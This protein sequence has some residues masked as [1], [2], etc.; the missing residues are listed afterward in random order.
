MH[1]VRINSR[2]IRAV[3]YDP[4]SRRMK[5]VFAAGHDYDFC[6]VPPRVYENLLASPSKGRFYN[7]HIKGRYPC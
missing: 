7:E 3:G 1:M 5:I 6:A 2:A 4:G